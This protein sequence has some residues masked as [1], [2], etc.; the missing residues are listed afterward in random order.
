[1]KKFNRLGEK[2]FVIGRVEN[3]KQGVE[4]I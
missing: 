1:V 3:G 4:Y 2:A